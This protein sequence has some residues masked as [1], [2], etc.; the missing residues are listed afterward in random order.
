MPLRNA[1]HERFA[2]EM[3]KGK[4]AV[5]AHEAAGYRPNDGN[6]SKL[7]RKP[8]VRARI[9]E[10]TGKAAERAEITVVSLLGELDAV[11]VMAMA[12]QQASAAVAAIREKGILSGK[13]I[14]RREQGE[15]GEFDRM[16][17]DELIKEILQ[18]N[19]EANIDIGEETQH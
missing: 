13:R 12:N 11:L 19:E 3:A 10:I 1:R 7:A 4:T 16:T 15:P 2:Q 17:D 8:E 6:A 14:E 9:T 5:H 18:M